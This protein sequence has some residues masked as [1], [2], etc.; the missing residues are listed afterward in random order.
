MARSV[1]FTRRR[2]GAVLLVDDYE[3]ARETM[4]EALESS[5]HQVIE[6]RNGQ[7]A[8]DLLVAEPRPSI[9]MIV[10]DLQMPVMDGWEFLRLLGTYLGLTSIPVLIV[11]GHPAHLDQVTHQ[12]IVGSLHPPY[13]V[14]ELVDLVNRYN[15]P[16]LALGSAK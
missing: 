3:E 10:L 2:T 7:E 1:S 5:G 15:Q 6:A 4:R 11:S 16:S 14:D 8:L 12:A 9:G 13:S